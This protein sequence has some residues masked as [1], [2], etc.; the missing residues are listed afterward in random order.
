MKSVLRRL[1]TSVVAAS[2][3][4]AVVAVIG[5][6]GAAGQTPAA[7]PLSPDVVAQFMQQ[8]QATPRTTVPVGNTGGAAVVIVKFTDY[9]CPGCG[10]T[11][12]LYKPVLQKYEA[13]FPGA[14]KFITKDFP[15][16]ASCNSW[17]TQTMHPASCAAA[18]AVALARKE[19][20][21]PEM[22]DW[23]YSNQQML[24]PD[25]VRRAAELIANV[26][27]FST[28]YAGAIEQVKADVGLGRLLDVNSTPTFFINGVKIAQALQPDL[29]DAAIA[30][31]LKK[32]GKIK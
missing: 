17:M 11:H 19:N 29:F 15:L 21:G 23:L 2:A 3:A 8:Y 7:S 9:Q 10:I 1:S 32:A 31:E 26:K 24:T 28:G 22:E 20:H 14:I 4:L 27:D 12:R 25:V 6:H 16:D 13:Q 5:L 30:Y 18:V